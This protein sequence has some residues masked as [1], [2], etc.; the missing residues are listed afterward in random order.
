LRAQPVRYFGTWIPP[1]PRLTVSSGRLWHAA[2]VLLVA[3][4][5][6]CVAL[7]LGAIKRM[8][9]FQILNKPFVLYTVRLGLPLPQMQL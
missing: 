4:E 3:L 6:P 5:K 1:N 7:T 2:S 9:Q 8:R